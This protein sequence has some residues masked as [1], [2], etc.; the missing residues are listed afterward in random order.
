MFVQD[1]DG[2][3]GLPSHAT[4]TWCSPG[5]VGGDVSVVDLVQAID[6]VDPDDAAQVELVRD[7]AG[8]LA[9]L[10]PDTVMGGR[11]D[12]LEAVRQIKG[13]AEAAE[14]MLLS[15]FV[16]PKQCDQFR[17]DG[18]AESEPKRVVRQDQA[19]EVAMALQVS[20]FTIMRRIAL[21]HQS[22]TT[23]PQPTLHWPMGCFPSPA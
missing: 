23:T 20:P 4:G 10:A 9:T 11:L 2:Q 1:A 12:A 17:P 22:C 18:A 3:P 5:G 19:L 21:A 7:L 6:A 13:Q 16:L 14:L 8:R 15:R